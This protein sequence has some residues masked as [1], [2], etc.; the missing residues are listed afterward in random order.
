MPRTIGDTLIACV[1]QVIDLGALFP[2]SVLQGSIALDVRVEQGSF[3]VGSKVR[4]V[5]PACEEEVE[6]VSVEML[7]DPHDV[8]VVRIHCPKP[9]SLSLPVG[10]VEGWFLADH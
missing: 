10:K 8:D 2:A 1:I 9:Q 4:L 6:I 3:L 5:G 7:R